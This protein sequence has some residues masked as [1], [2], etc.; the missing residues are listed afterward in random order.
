MAKEGKKTDS[1]TECPHCGGKVI[2]HGYDCYSCERCH[3]EFGPK[4]K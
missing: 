2:D 4:Q 1:P 3:R